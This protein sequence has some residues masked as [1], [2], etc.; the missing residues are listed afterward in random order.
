MT[1]ASEA[2]PVRCLGH[3]AAPGS[4]AAED[5]LPATPYALGLALS[6][7]RCRCGSSLHF[8]SETLN[9]LIIGNHSPS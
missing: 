4:K 7:G 5:G 8:R 2:R 6:A 9:M 3:R 1:S